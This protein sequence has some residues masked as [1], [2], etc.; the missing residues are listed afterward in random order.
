[1]YRRGDFFLGEASRH[2]Q[3]LL[4]K[5]AIGVVELL[6]IRFVENG[7]HKGIAV[8]P[9]LPWNTPERVAA[10]HTVLIGLGWL[11]AHSQQARFGAKLLGREAIRLDH[12]EL[13]ER[14]RHLAL[15]KQAVCLLKHR[16][17]MCERLLCCEEFGW[18]HSCYCGGM[19]GTT[20]R[21][22][23]GEKLASKGCHLGRWRGSGGS[24]LAL[25]RCLVTVQGQH[26]FYGSA[27]AE[28]AL[29][30]SDQGRCGVVTDIDNSEAA[31]D[32]RGEFH[33]SLQTRMHYRLTLLEDM[34]AITDLHAMLLSLIQIDDIPGADSNF[35][36]LGGDNY[37]S[38]HASLGR[39]PGVGG[40]GWWGFKRFDHVAG[41]N[42]VKGVQD[43]EK[44]DRRLHVLYHGRAHWD[45]G[46]P[47]RLVG[48]W[49]AHRSGGPHNA[50]LHPGEETL[51]FPRI[52]DH[53]VSRCDMLSFFEGVYDGA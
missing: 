50:N 33:G 5:E 1:L 7:P 3:D 32:L 51:V 9:L 44:S 4:G 52:Y 21:F 36:V 6:A 46:Y 43:T 41:L 45:N 8:D 49:L 34:K 53:T 12:T 27:N 40:H 22:E 28:F 39:M 37:A 26:K 31:K 35:V 24:F 18:L 25:G 2:S 10:P 38:D 30:S 11:P 20:G 48:C 17:S 13:G 15:L 14:L 23:T 29:S 42:S 19:Y 16:F 47:Q